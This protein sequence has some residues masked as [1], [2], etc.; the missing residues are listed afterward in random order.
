MTAVVRGFRGHQPRVA[1]DV[2]VADLVAIIGDV[3]I[4]ARSS[5][6]Y[7]TVVRGDVMPIRIGVETSIQ[8]NSVVHVTAG[9]P[10]MVTGHGSAPARHGRDGRSGSGTEVGDRVTVGHRVIL[11]ACIVEDDCIIGMGSVILD[12]AVVGKGSVVGAGAVITPGT[13]IPPR[14]MVLGSPGRVKR[15]ISDEEIMWIGFSA[16][17]YVDLAQRYLA[18][19]G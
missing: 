18:S 19:A 7:G 13:V 11:H 4:G 9:V 14:S 5:I 6:W 1:D 2:F 15:P 10:Q 8:D 12:R 17:H 3:V 16:Q